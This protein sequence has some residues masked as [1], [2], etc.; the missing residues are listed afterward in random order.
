MRD[1]LQSHL[2]PKE[3]W[4]SPEHLQTEYLGLQA[5]RGQMAQ[6]GHTAHTES[7]VVA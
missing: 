2:H 3:S 7:W 6:Q 5:G 4:V 1:I